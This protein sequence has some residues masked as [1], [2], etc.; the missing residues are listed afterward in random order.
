MRIKFW[1]TRGSFPNR[2]SAEDMT[3]CWQNGKYIQEND[4]GSDTTCIEIMGDTDKSVIIDAGSG[5]TRLPFM[6]SDEFHILFSHLHWDHLHGLNFFVP[7][8]VPGKKIHLY[9]VHEEL[10][11]S[12]KTLFNGINFPVEYGQLGAD[13]EFHPLKVY[14]QVE[15][16]G[17]K[18]TPFLL[19]HPG[20]AYGFNIEHGGKRISTAFDTEF[21]RSSPKD[22][23]EDHAFY[24]NLDALIFD[25]QYK[26]KEVVRDKMNWG[27]A[28]PDFGVDL[29]LRERIPMVIMTHHDP[30]VSYKELALRES[31]AI[32][33]CKSQVKAISKIADQQPVPTK[34][35]F[36]SREL[37]VE[38]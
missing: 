36:S 18:V 27:H 9:G 11:A 2:L 19:D 1:G 28:S 14:E 37:V 6:S 12:V 24:Q 26:L 5:I 21:I 35:V 30:A 16:Q 29:A 20:K 25:A 17:L 22:L 38:V 33:Y 7:I 23:G 34:V 15:I 8:Y 10:E 3:F 4:Y 32:T 31:E 13:I